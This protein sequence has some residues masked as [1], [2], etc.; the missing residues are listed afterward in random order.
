[1]LK[2]VVSLIYN[3]YTFFV[4]FVHFV[5]SLSHPAKMHT[6]MLLC[7]IGIA[8][9]QIYTRGGLFFKIHTDHLSICHNK[10]LMSTILLFYCV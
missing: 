2:I 3:M 5:V 7:P 10:T 8:G 1:M 6:S 4:A 9:G